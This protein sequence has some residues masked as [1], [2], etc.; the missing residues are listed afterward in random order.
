M[1]AAN[2]SPSNV[3]SLAKLAGV[4]VGAEAEFVIV[5]VIVAAWTR[6]TE[7]RLR[8]PVRRGFEVYIL[9]DIQRWTGEV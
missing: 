7:R 4:P 6:Q 1:C 2:I 5:L 8:R 3:V 9:V